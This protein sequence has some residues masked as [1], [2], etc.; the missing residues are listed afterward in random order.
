M[1]RVKLMKCMVACLLSLTMVLSCVSTFGM[2]AADT[3]PTAP[4]AVYATYKWASN[5]V[6]TGSVEASVYVLKEKS[7]NT[8]KAGTKS[9]ATT[10]KEAGEDTYSVSMTDLGIKKPDKEV[11]LYVCSGDF[12][13]EGQNMFRPIRVLQHLEAVEKLHWPRR[14]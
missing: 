9:K 1:K 6:D 4:T 13:V 5:S 14:K 10:T 7:G 11:Y 12:E 2:K 3:T 8:I